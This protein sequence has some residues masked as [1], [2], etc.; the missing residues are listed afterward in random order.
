MNDP[1]TG[2]LARG[3]KRCALSK[4]IKKAAPRPSETSRRERFWCRFIAFCWISVQILPRARNEVTPAVNLINRRG[5]A[6][7]SAYSA[8]KRPFLLIMGI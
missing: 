1:W 6:A 4:R 8:N 2:I 3:M 7:I 5:A